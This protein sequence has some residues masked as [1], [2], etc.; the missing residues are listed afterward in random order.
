MFKKDT[1]GSVVYSGLREM[2][3]RE[4]SRGGFVLVVGKVLFF[5]GRYPRGSDREF[6]LSVG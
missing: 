6:G 1:V 4:G 5:R 2:V 3:L